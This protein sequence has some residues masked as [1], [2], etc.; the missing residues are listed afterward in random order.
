MFELQLCDLRLAN[1]SG[2]RSTLPATKDNAAS[3]CA[4]LPRV[5]LMF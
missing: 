1:H 5:I 4:S 2:Q 3:H